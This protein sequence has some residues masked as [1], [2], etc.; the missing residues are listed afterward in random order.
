M[1]SDGYIDPALFGFLSMI[2]GILMSPRQTLRL[3]TSHLAA[4]HNY[5]GLNPMPPSRSPPAGCLTF[6]SSGFTSSRLSQFPK[7]GGTCLSQ[8]VPAS[9]LL[10]GPAAWRGAP[11]WGQKAGCRL[12]GVPM[13]RG[14]SKDFKTSVSS[15]HW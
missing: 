1:G 9:P 6:S 2:H 15:P 10:V 5:L 4:V 11:G 7:S 12:P 3:V 13:A 8:G 14:H